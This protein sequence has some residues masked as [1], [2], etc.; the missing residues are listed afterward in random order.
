MKI[1]IRIIT[2]DG[3]IEVTDIKGRQIIDGVG[4][5]DVDDQFL[6]DMLDRIRK[7][8]GEKGE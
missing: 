7:E 4:E 1:T 2:Q 8:Y 3:Y 5:T 6:L